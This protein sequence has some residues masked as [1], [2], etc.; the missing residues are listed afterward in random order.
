MCRKAVA[1]L[2]RHIVPDGISD[3]AT[4]SE[5]YG[6][7]DSEE[8]RST[9]TIEQDRCEQRQAEAM[10]M[11]RIVDGIASPSPAAPKD[12]QGV[13][14][15]WFSV[16]NSLP[17]VETD[18]LVFGKRGDAICYSVAGIFTGDTHVPLGSLTGR[19]WLAQNSEEE[20][21]FIVSHWMPLPSAPQPT[22]TNK[23]A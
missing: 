7:F 5:L 2:N 15:E 4:L 18:V 16:N 14:P 11:A 6:I 9:N 10:S 19:E 22:D 3:F 13:V 17:E 20:L 21:R 23:G 12:A 1:V 8:Y